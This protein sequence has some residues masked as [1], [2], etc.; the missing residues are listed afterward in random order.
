MFK[1]LGDDSPALDNTSTE[2][3]NLTE[4]KETS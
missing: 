3:D 2:V 4:M 1:R